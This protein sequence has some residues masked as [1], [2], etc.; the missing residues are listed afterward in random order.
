VATFD[1]EVWRDR[2]SKRYY[3]AHDSK[4]D[5][6]AATYVCSLAAIDGLTL[7]IDWCQSKSLCIK[8]TNRYGGYFDPNKKEVQV[9]ARLAPEM[10]LIVLLHECG[11]FLVDVHRPKH[12]I[13]RGYDALDALA[14]K[15]TES[16]VDIVD[17]ELEAWRRGLSLAKRLK[18]KL[19]E[20][21]YNQVRSKCVKTYMKWA[22][23]VDGYGDSLKEDE[24]DKV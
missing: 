14:G 7:L 24:D 5:T 21:K 13:N 1:P 23:K 15:T 6:A 11:H 3:G 18:I 19:N 16:R 8:F 9:N 2:A 4:K 10:Q 20:E 22:V 12:R 17:E